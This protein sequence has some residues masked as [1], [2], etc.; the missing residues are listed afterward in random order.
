MTM[1]PAAT[2]DRRDVLVSSF[3]GQAHHGFDVSAAWL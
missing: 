3:D 1:R 2:P